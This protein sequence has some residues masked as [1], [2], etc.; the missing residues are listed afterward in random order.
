[1][2]YMEAEISSIV[3]ARHKIIH[4]LD[5]GVHVDLGSMF[6]FIHS[7]ADQLET[8]AEVSNLR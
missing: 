5:T 2:K 1:V 7:G 3:S 8:M 6:I 4:Q